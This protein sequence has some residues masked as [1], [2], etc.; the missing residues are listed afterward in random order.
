MKEIVRVHHTI[1]IGGRTR[2]IREL[3]CRG[4]IV[5]AVSRLLKTPLVLN[6]DVDW[7]FKFEEVESPIEGKKL[8]KASALND[9]TGPDFFYDFIVAEDKEVIAKIFIMAVKLISGCP[10]EEPEEKEE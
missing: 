6:C 8:Y 4:D 10:V 3:T 7:S 1:N 5:E 2:K 9:G